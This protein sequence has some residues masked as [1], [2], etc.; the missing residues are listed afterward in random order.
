MKQMTRQSHLRAFTFMAIFASVG[1]FAANHSA[2]AQNETSPAPACVQK[3]APADAIEAN[4]QLMDRF[5]DFINT[6]DKKMADELV[7]KSA[8]F[9]VPGQSD[10]LKG[11]QGYLAT[12]QMMRGG[13]PNI[14][15]KLEETVVEPNKV[16]ARFMMHGTH[17][18]TFFG[19]PATGKQI[20][21]QALNIY[22]LCNGQIIQ[23]YGQP[24]MLGLMQQIG[25]VPH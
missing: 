13:F 5:V 11:P 14:Q 9:Y 24:D 12:I 4:K 1:V 7:S 17:K 6:A 25:A 19:L 18:G 2:R 23:E 15:W 22:H 3:A 10:P 8:I 20:S 21:V 16:A